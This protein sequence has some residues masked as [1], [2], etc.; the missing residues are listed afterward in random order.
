MT[1]KARYDTKGNLQLLHNGTWYDNAYLQGTL[2][3]KGVTRSGDNW[4]SHI[5]TKNKQHNLLYTDSHEEAVLT[6][7]TAEQCLGWQSHTTAYRYAYGVLGKDLP[8]VVTSRQPV[9]QRVLSNN[10]RYDAAGNTQIQHNGTWCDSQYL[11]GTLQVQGVARFGGNWQAYIFSEN[12]Q[13]NLIHTESFKEAVL[14]RF[15]AEQCLG[16]QSHTTAYRYAY[17]ILGKDLSVC[18]TKRQ[19]RSFP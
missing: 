5:Y 1:Q 2:Q 19:K 13:H 7:L 18:V 17:G 16:W 8:I 4:R 12:K 15:T 3:V 11:T 14:A 10:E 6:R 9:E